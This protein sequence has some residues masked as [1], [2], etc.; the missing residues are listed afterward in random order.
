[1]KKIKEISFSHI[2]V[3]VISI[4]TVDVGLLYVLDSLGYFSCFLNG[5]ECF[6]NHFTICFLTV[7]NLQL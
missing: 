3:L 6:K 1:M 5:I 4:I 7:R 2:M